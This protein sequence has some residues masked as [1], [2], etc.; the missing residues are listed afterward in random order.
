MS[1]L[2][3]QILIASFSSVLIQ[4]AK[5]PLVAIYPWT[6]A[7]NEKGTS[8]VAINTAE[9]TLRKLFEKRASMEVVSEARCKAV[10]Q[11]LDFAEWPYTVEELGQLPRLEDPKKLLEFGETLG[12]EYVCSGTLGWTVRSV[13]VALGPKTKAN[14]NI[15]VIIIDVKNKEV[16]L[17]QRDFKSDSA[18][19]EKWYETA[20]ALLVTWGITLFSGGPKTPHM[21]NAAVKGIGAAT[22]PFF[23]SV[24]RR[25]R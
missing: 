9:D 7:E 25:I 4:E 2:I 11:Q 5:P 16:V 6:F 17:E 19:A 10:W 15:N 8:Q 12:V 20:G 18:K 22:D 14:A 23:A 13:W 1:V 24:S 3:A 21:Q